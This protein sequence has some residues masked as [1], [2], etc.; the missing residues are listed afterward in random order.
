MNQPR[1]ISTFLAQQEDRKLKRK[2]VDL[3][4][5]ADV[6]LG[7]SEEY[8]PVRFQTFR[9][10]Q[11]LHNYNYAAPENTKPLYRHV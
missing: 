1:F 7:D 3:M 8:K 11:H 2:D 9:L 4:K 10:T 5:G 6:S